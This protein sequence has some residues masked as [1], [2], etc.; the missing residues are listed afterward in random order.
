MLNDTLLE[1]QGENIHDEKQHDEAPE[2]THQRSDHTIQHQSELAKEYQ[3]TEDTQNL[4]DFAQTEQPQEAKVDTWS[5]GFSAFFACAQQNKRQD[6][7][8]DRKEHQHKVKPGKCKQ[9]I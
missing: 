6:I 4:H 7:L 1:E 3:R 2:D 9:N 8:D 5:T